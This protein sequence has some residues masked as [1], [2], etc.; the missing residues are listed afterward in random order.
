MAERK[1]MGNVGRWRARGPAVGLARCWGECT[2]TSP[3]WG[4]AGVQHLTEERGEALGSGAGLW[5]TQR[6]GGS[7]TAGSDLDWGRGRGGEP[8]GTMREGRGPGAGRAQGAWGLILLLCREPLHLV[9]SSLL[10]L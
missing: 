9:D 4:R 5:G 6:W 7:L 8:S 1:K 3:L 2:V 10:L